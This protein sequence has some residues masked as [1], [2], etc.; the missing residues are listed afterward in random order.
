LQTLLFVKRQAHDYMGGDD[1]MPGKSAFD[2][3]CQ[4][5]NGVSHCPDPHA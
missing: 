2:F 5:I 4:V 1:A 3:P